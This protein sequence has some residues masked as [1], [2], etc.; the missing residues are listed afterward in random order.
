MTMEWSDSYKIGDANIDSQHRHL[1]ALA[2]QFLTAPDKDSLTVC[3]MQLYK[4][5][6]EHF[7]HEEQLMRKVGYPDLLAHAERHNLLL[8]RLNAIS[9]TIAHDRVNRDDLER[10]MWDWAMHHVPDDDVRLSNYL[11]S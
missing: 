2:N 6:R 10:L 7:E 3:A 1:F 11:T 9:E 5:T 8:S 4:H